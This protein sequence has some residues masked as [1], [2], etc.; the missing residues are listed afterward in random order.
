MRIAAGGQEVGADGFHR[1]VE[2]EYLN[3]MLAAKGGDLGTESVGAPE[4]VIVS[5][6]HQVYSVRF[7]QLDPLAVALAV[8]D[9]L[10]EPVVVA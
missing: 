3:A 9:D 2:G 6:H 8:A 7:D 10:M 4:A 1:L 5:A